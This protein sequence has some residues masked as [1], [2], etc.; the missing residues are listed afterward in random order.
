[1]GSLRRGARIAEMEAVHI[2]LL[3]GDLFARKC[4]W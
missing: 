4:G 3:R 1:M 2:H